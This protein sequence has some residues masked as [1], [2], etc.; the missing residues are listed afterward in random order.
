MS[1]HVM[2]VLFFLIGSH[3]MKVKWC[4]FFFLAFLQPQIYSSTFM[5][6]VKCLQQYQ[7][8]LLG[9][10]RIMVLQEILYVD[11]ELIR[12][13]WH[14][15]P[16]NFTLQMFVCSDLRK[17][18]SINTWKRDSYFSTVNIEYVISNVS[19]APVFV[20]YF[21]STLLRFYN[22]SLNQLS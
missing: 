19:M 8:F 16:F 5:L 6:D 7:S 18:A 20:R 22:D 2:K 1:C 9:S 15:L 4:N 17:V 21:L 11:H 14:Y 10:P 3:V 13:L 12:Q